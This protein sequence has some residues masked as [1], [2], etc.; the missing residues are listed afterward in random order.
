[1]ERPIYKVRSRNRHL[2]QSKNIPQRIWLATIANT[3]L[4]PKLMRLQMMF[5]R[6][7]LTLDR[8]VLPHQVP[9]RPRLDQWH[10]RTNGRVPRSLFPRRTAR[11]MALTRLIKA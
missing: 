7:P 11:T 5:D 8:I 9:H 4:A 6:M 10:A 3:M 1:M 2:R